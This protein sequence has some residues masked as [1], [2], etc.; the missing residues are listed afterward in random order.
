[1]QDYKHKPM[2]SVDNIGPAG[3]INSNVL[4]M[5]QW[6][7]FQ[8]GRGE[9]QGQR[10]IS[11]EQLRETWTDHIEI[12]PG[13][14]YGMAW[15]LREWEGQ[16]VLEHGGNVDGFA[17]QV[18]L[19]PESNLGFVLL[20]N[21]YVTALQQLSI[22]MVWEALLG[23][24]EEADA[25][26]EDEGYEPYLGEY[27]NHFGPLKDREFTVLVQNDRL[28]LDAAGEAV[29]ELKEPDEEGRWYFVATDQAAV[30]FERDD[31]GN[32]IA[33]LIHQS[34]L[35]FEIPRA[36][37]E[38]KPEIDLDELQ[39]YFGSYRSEELA[40]T[41]EVLVQNNRLAIDWPGE[42]VFEMYPPDEEGIWVFRVSKDF[43]L[44][45]NET[46]DGQ[47]ESLT[48]YQAGKVF[49]MTRVEGKPLP[50][51]EEIL[52][53][54]KTD[55]RQAAMSEM[56][57]Y[58]ITGTFFSPQSGVEGTFS[59][60]VSGTDRYRT[61]YDYGRYGYSRAALNGD[62]AWNESSFGPFDELHGKLLEQAKQRH[63][64][65]D[66]VDWRDFYDSVQVLRSDELDGHEV[67]VLRLKWGDLPPV[68]TYIDATTGDVLKTDVVVINEG[69]I[70]IPITVRCEDYRE[71]HGIRI[72]FRT[73]SSNEH[74]G[75]SIVQYEAIDINLDIED[76]FFILKP[77]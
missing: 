17:A 9:Y 8:L 56:G 3:A 75:S 58:R 29:Y 73:I 34:G 77:P 25:T 50:T 55:S 14:S 20:T 24:Q 66:F 32:V 62:R 41:A 39:K 76:D 7:R 18:A 5:A 21:V 53:L 31:Q 13:I 36:G 33:M 30:S 68:T 60:Y 26:G 57:T 37:F 15:M 11:E 70:G 23:E 52:A 49:E 44:R 46:Q 69:G 2:R 74:S 35:A 10:L 63:P 1:L 22:N 38:I 71:V 72:P 40:V 27:I 51:L 43:T 28:A 61:D 59:T 4:D 6:L 54:R 67:Y 64:A 47:I 45:F 16:P 65:L 12:I 19:L 48:Y 42:M